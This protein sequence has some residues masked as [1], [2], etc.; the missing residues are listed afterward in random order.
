MLKGKKWKICWECEYTVEIIWKFV[1]YKQILCNFVK[2][3]KGK[4]VKKWKGKRWKGEYFADKW[5]H[6]LHNEKS[7]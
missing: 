2:K 3:W 7:E 1:Q 5:E 6:K 4:I